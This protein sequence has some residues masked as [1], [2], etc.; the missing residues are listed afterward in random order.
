[1][2]VALSELV[3]EWLRGLTFT[4][5]E[6]LGLVY[7]W[8]HGPMSMTELAARIPLSRAAVT[9]LT[10]RLEAQ[11][12]IRRTA[13]KADRRRTIV[14]LTNSLRVSIEALTGA[15]HTDIAAHEAQF[16]DDEKLTIRRWSAGMEQISVRH[17]L[18]LRARSDEE[19]PVSD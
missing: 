4:A 7:L 1:M 8:A 18:R 11:G 3:G 14:M 17:T 16:L 6:R 10:D 9:S 5:H 13:D 19:L 15:W 12:Y 2:S